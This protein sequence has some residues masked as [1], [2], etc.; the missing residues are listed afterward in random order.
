M[1]EG[2][3]EQGSTSRKRA[4]SNKKFFIIGGVAIAAIV[5]VVVF[6]IF[7]S[8]MSGNKIELYKTDA[9]F[10]ST[11]DN[12]E[13]KYALFKN[14][15][16]KVTDFAY[17]QVS[18]FINGY[19]FVKSLDGKD[20]IIDHNGNMTVDFGEYDNISA[21][22][23]IYEA[24]KDQNEK[25]ILGN[26]E[27]LVKEYK[28]YDYAP[29]SPYVIV[30]FE[31]NKYELYNALGDKLADFKSEEKPVITDDDPETVTAVSAKGAL[32]IL[33]NTNFRPANTIA[34]INTLYDIDEATKDGKLIT[35]FEHGKHYDDSAKRAIYSAERFAELDN[36]CT[37]LDISD[38]FT[39]EE[40][41]YATCEKEDKNMLIRNNT[42]TDIAVSSY[43]DGYTVYDENHYV[44]YNSDDKKAEFFVNGESKKT[45]DANYRVSVSFKGYQLNDYKARKVTLF[46]LNGDELIALNDTS[47]SSEIN[48]VDDNDN[49]IV[50]DSKKESNERYVVMNKNDEEL[51]GRYYNITPHGKYYSAI[52]RSNNTSDLLDK[53]GKVIVSGAYNEFAFYEDNQYILARKGDSGNRQYDVVDVDGKSIKGTIEG[54]VTYYKSGYFRAI[55]DNKIRYYTL[56]GKLIHEYES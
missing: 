2:Q 41:I 33:S 25:L 48:G 51:S 34:D 46:D 16:S 54:T 5:A 56:D 29:N 8:N 45:I 12:G 39:N 18:Q 55:Q 27:E 53:D 38:N 49:V 20:G 4:R 24:I 14:D 37:D 30:S 43:G 11:R 3:P 19:A 35:F 28:A 6:I 47:S 13:T 21:H 40:R 31:D 26:G 44:R 10:L 15:G 36:A 42:V 50:R 7:L 32:I 22:M 52:N 23:G 1:P 17:S 9:F